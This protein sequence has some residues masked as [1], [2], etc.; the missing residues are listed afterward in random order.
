MKLIIISIVLLSVFA[1]RALP[2]YE[3]NLD[4]PV[5]E[6]YASILAEFKEP[7]NVAFGKVLN[8]VKLLLPALRVM[9]K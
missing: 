2:E 9:A 5:Q 3:I 7:A 8:K 1:R 4:L 6:R